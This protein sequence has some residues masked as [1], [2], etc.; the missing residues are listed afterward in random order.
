MYFLIDITAEFSLINVKGSYVT[1]LGKTFFRKQYT[2]DID[3]KLVSLATKTLETRTLP[4]NR[5][6]LP[7]FGTIAKDIITDPLG[8]VARGKTREQLVRDL[9]TASNVK[10]PPKPE[11]IAKAGR[12][13]S[14]AMT[15]YVRNNKEDLVVNT[16]GALAS[17]AGA[18]TGVP[19]MKY[20]G[21]LGGALVAR[22]G[23]QD[24]KATKTAIQKLKTDEAFKQANAL[25]KLRKVHGASLSELKELALQGKIKEN[26][27]DDVGG[28]VVGNAVAETAN[29]AGAGIPL[30]GAT[31]A[32]AVAEDIR[33][34]A[35]RI[36]VGERK[37]K[38][39]KDTIVNI[40]NRPKE[41]IK[42]GQQREQRVRDKINNYLKGL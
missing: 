34:A 15:E 40:V 2:K 16:S 27:I 9:L 30:I 42:K 26:A 23:V 18:S 3:K 22:K 20:L 1:R 11:I 19:G 32:M 13:A 37:A 5:E 17:I 21:D 8:A 41:F 29:A 35:K 33:K 25:D 24:L 10:I 14:K 4:T 7:V 6:L 12:E 31:G 28:F 39:V 36:E 38:V